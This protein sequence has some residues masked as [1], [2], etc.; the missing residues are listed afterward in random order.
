M[1]SVALEVNPVRLRAMA[2][3]AAPVI[4]PLVR[5]RHP[6]ADGS[7]ADR[8]A[9][10]RQRQRQ[11]LGTDSRS[12]SH[13]DLEEM[14]TFLEADLFR[15]M[16]GFP[17]VSTRDDFTAEVWTRGA[18]RDQTRVEFDGLPLFNPLHS[19]GVLT[20]IN[21]GGVGS[22]IL[23]PGVRSASLGDATAGVV[24]LSSRSATGSGK[25]RGSA[26][27]S[28]ASARAMVEHR[29]GNGRGWMI[30]ARRSYVD[31]LTAALH[32]FAS[33]SVAEIPYALADVVGRVDLPIANH[34]AVEISGI[35][36]DDRLRGDI[37]NVLY[38]N[39][40]HWGIAAGRVT[41]VTES[42]SLRMRHTVGFS[43]FGAT[44]R[45]V[46]RPASAPA[47]YPATGNAVAHLM[48]RTRIDQGDDWSG[49]FEVMRR[50][51][52][53]DGAA[54]DPT[55]IPGASDLAA[56]GTFG[57]REA[58]SPSRRLQ[59]D[60]GLTQ[61]SLWAERRVR[62]GARVVLGAGVRIDA[63]AALANASTIRAAPR[64]IVRYRG[65]G[66]HLTLAAG[67]GRSFQYTQALASTDIIRSG[68][69]ASGVFVTAGDTVPAIR[70]DL[71]TAGSEYWLSDRWLAAVN[72]Y[73][74]RAAGIVVPDPSPGP[75]GDRP[76]FVSGKNR[77]WGVELSARRLTGRWTMSGSYSFGRSRLEAAGLSYPAPTERLHSISAAS[78]FRLGRAIR[79]GGTLLAAS[80]MPF[81][82]VFATRFLC[83]DPAACDRT[84]PPVLEAPSA[85]RGPV[86]SS[87]NLQA[88]WTR[89]FRNWTLDVYVQLRN[90]LTHTNDV[91]YNSS[92]ECSDDTASGIGRAIRRLDLFEPGLPRLPV[93]GLRALF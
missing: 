67:Y 87:L 61:L 76:L 30:A 40:G 21:A 92:C 19:L 60:Q 9:A 89:S 77:A 70:S 73:L 42:G 51:Q 11:Y 75:V 6:R 85:E 59:M 65:A 93:I 20:G 8:L 12:L 58:G 79:L 78:T 32:D 17:G 29:G 13:E 23:H 53:Y 48:F 10:V 62:V 39:T 36:Q 49:G 44:L 38:G 24:S 1:L 63:S 7:W 33:P 82:R 68:L 69:W 22:A 88:D 54:P 4:Q 52:H 2:T 46:E 37:P 81:T 43:G 55:R 41:L 15:A 84:G 90:V 3:E 35:W 50:S 16:H 71:V 34:H 14:N 66:D 56:R 31:G 72:V 80:G 5:A 28:L 57:T 47:G 86:Y 45:E 26:A 74:R 27:L 83:G 64:L 25:V 18:P 91:T